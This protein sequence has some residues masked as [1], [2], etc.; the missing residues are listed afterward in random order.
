MKV[1]AINSG[2]TPELQQVSLKKM[3]LVPNFS[4]FMKQQSMCFMK[5]RG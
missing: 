1:V 4:V 5:L 3:N 2:Q